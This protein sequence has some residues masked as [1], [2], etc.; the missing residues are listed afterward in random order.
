MDSAR[1]QRL[2]EEVN[3]GKR[4]P[5]ALYIHPDTLPEVLRPWV[6]SAKEIGGQPPFTVIKLSTEEMRLSLLDYPG[7]DDQGFP[8][9]HSSTVVDLSR[10]SCSKRSYEGDHAPV[11][12]RKELLLPPGDPRGRE[13]AAL[14]QQAEEA[15]LFQQSSLIGTV[16]GWQRALAAAGLRV[17][18]HS[19]VPESPERIQRHRTALVRYRLSTPMQALLQHG[20]LDGDRD[21]FDYGCGRGGDLA[22]L[23]QLGVPASGWDPHYAADREKVAAEVVNLGFVLNVIENPTERAEA[24]AGAWAL[25]KTVLAVAVLIAGRSAWEKHRLYRDGVITSK[26]TFQKYFSQEELRSLL[27]EYTGRRP[28]A[29]AP[30]LFFVFR[31]E[32]DEQTFLVERLSRRPRAVPTLPEPERVARP[33]KAERPPKG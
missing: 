1:W 25:T 32:E 24:L 10:K 27:Q 3:G 14:T 6:E 26:G 22:Q 31:K 17:E 23:G 13:W 28:I 16:G 30:G 29:M 4:M 19:L 8:I 12:H 18:G 21:V 9:L 7:F 5:D 15:G 2:V 20:F 11:L 33:P